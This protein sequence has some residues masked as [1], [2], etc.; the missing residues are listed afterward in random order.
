MEDIL[1]LAKQ[2]LGIEDILVAAQESNFRCEIPRTA[3]EV[4]SSAIR[5]IPFK[6][7]YW[8]FC[9]YTTTPDFKCLEEDSLNAIKAFAPAS[10]FLITHSYSTRPAVLKFVK[11]LINRKG[12]G[13]ATDGDLTRIDELSSIDGCTDRI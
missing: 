1:Y 5:V 11:K 13:I 9:D 6:G 4:E 12:G 10:I 3:A 2:K 7:T 8:D